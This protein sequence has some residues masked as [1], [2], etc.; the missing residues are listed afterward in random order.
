MA[1]NWSVPFSSIGIDNYLVNVTS[2]D[3]NNQLEWV[4]AHNDT[5]P[6]PFRVLRVDPTAGLVP[7]APS[8]PLSIGVTE[9]TVLN[10]TAGV[11]LYGV[12]Q[13]VDYSYDPDGQSSSS[14]GSETGWVMGLWGVLWVGP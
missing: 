12:T 10:L 2:N 1:F 9:P 4:H 14:T 7:A 13:P 11:Y 8:V 6:Y 5:L 3:P